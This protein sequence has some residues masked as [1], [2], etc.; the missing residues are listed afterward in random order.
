MGLLTKLKSLLG[1][2]EDRS[3]VRRSESGV[4]IEREPDESVEPDAE[5]ESAVKGV[6]TDTEESSEVAEPDDTA[7]ER[8]ESDDETTPRPTWR[9]A[10]TPKRPKTP[11]RASPPKT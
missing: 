1:L 4:T 2:S 3:Q 8:A 10:K 9:R 11:R 7:A 5:V 6:D